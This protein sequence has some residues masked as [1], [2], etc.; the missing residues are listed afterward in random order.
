MQG[1]HCS[2]TPIDFKFLQFVSQILNPGMS[3]MIL[4]PVD[5]LLRGQ[6]KFEVTTSVALVCFGSVHKGR[7]SANIRLFPGFLLWTRD[8]RTHSAF[9]LKLHRSSMTSPSPALGSFFSS[10]L[11]SPPKL[12]VER[13]LCCCIEFSQCWRAVS[14]AFFRHFQPEWVTVLA[15]VVLSN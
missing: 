5:E 3:P 9:K 12:P 14:S 6:I 4:T 11:G 2:I 7:L 13:V 8:P 15:D 10:S 1:L